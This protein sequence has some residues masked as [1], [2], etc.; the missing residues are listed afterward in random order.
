MMAEASFVS[1]I[2]TPFTIATVRV[3][4]GL[5]LD[6][7]NK[8]TNT[9]A[10]AEPQTIYSSLFFFMV[11]RSVYST[12]DRLPTFYTDLYFK[13]MAETLNQNR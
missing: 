2:A 6:T 3:S 7:L 5:A 12:P 4:P 1:L 13:S 11:E 8:I 10:I 9:R